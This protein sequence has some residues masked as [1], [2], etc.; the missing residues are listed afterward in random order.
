MAP[1]NRRVLGL[2]GVVVVII[3]IVLIAGSGGQAATPPAT[4]AASIVPSDA[5]AYIHVSTDPS[6]P[7]VPS[8]LSLAARFP[9]YRT[10]RDGLMARLGVTG[11]GVA[12]DFARDVRPWLGKEIALALFDTPTT[13][14]GSLI[15]VGI[16]NRRQAKRFIAGLPS[17]GTATYKG[18]TITGHPKALDTAFVG[19][20]L[21]IGHSASIR[22]AIDVAAGRAPSLRANPSY[23]R[24]TT[25]EPAARAADAYISATGVTRLIAARTGIVGE[26]GALLYQPTL[27]G[28][29]FALT[30]ASGGFQVHVKSVFNPALTRGN[31]PSFVPSLVSAVP[32]GAALFLDVTNLNRLF[33]RVVRTIG[34]GA[35][36][37]KLLLKLGIALTAQGVNVHRDIVSLFQR[38]SAVVIARHG[39]A[40]VLTVLTHTSAP[41]VTR[42]VFAQL[43]VPLEQLFAPAGNAAGQAPLFNQVTVGGVDAH[44]LV[45][46]PGLQFDYA[47]S[48]HELLL[49]TSLQG[50]ASVAHH[51]RSLLDDTAYR[52]TL[53]NH[54][55]RVT[56]LLFLD[57]NQLLSLG[58]QT[59]LITGTRYRALKPDLE[60]V[61]AIGLDSTSG[62]A[63]STAELFLQIP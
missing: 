42:R 15:V 20:Y 48:G 50:I 34:I 21:V 24:A 53:G 6:R 7:S 25:S 62:E 1:R 2:L 45:L 47:V 4:G 59:G 58:E 11:P 35:R 19:R 54:P 27:V 31:A 3:L 28:V 8:A 49:S 29:A 10:L 36:I 22:A 61:H 16:G 63:E 55:A 14:S 39:D 18:T 37:P 26:I 5:L 9:G 56:S 30:P 60:R 41:N 33:P 43:E 44:Q 32:S 46:A 23:Q 51:A 52:L 38:E 17:D 13:T 40:P 12:V 57:L